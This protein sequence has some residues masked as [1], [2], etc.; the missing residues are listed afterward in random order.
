MATMGEAGDFG[1]LQPLRPLLDAVECPWYVAG[2]WAIDLFLGAVTRP[3]AD[4]DVL[5]FREHQEQ[6]RHRLPIHRLHK[7]VPAPGGG[8]EE[9]WLPGDVLE[10]PVHQLRARTAQVDFDIFLADS[11][12]AMWVYRRD[13]RIARLKA[14]IGGRSPVGI[15]FLVPEIVLL[16]KARNPAPKDDADFS[17]VAP[18]LSRHSQRWLLTALQT[19]HP[20]SPWIAALKNLTER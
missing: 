8:I 1:P 15:P 4:I 10:L 3:H 18:R 7:I 13:T 2:G 16:F 9:P 12:G 20:A 6:L 11:V 14:D 19:A 5:V 17:R